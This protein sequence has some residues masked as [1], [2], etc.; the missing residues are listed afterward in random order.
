M[1]QKTRK[2]GLGV[3][4]LHD[5]LIQLELPMVKRGPERIGDVMRFIRAEAET[6]P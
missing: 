1:T 6:A 2:I 3:M 5:M 4:G